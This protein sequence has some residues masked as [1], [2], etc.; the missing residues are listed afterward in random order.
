MPS[1]KQNKVF[2][3]CLNPLINSDIVLLL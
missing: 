3:K 1:L 2:N